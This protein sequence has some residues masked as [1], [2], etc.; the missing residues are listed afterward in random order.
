M[1]L[2]IHYFE[3]NFQ[4]SMDMLPGFFSFRSMPGKSRITMLLRTFMYLCYVCCYV[5]M[6]RALRVLIKSNLKAKTFVTEKITPAATQQLAV[7]DGH[8]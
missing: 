6:C 2:L 8:I 1:C 4:N 5:C 3:L 7:T